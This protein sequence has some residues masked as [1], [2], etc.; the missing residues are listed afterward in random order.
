MSPA[1]Q[2]LISSLPLVA[3]VLL[4][5]EDKVSR[6]VHEARSAPCCSQS[7][8][9]ASRHHGI[10]NH[11]LSLTISSVDDYLR[12][13]RQKTSSGCVFI[14]EVDPHGTAMRR[15]VFQLG[16]DHMAASLDRQPRHF[17]T[18]VSRA[19]RNKQLHASTVR[20]SP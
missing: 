16:R 5:V 4:A 15:L 13:M 8:V 7:D 10:P 9:S 12:P 14:A 2:V 19:A 3:V 17:R 11:V 18:K 20:P 6:K 1:A